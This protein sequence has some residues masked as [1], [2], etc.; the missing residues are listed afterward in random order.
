MILALDSE[1]VVALGERRGRASTEAH[2]ALA[3]AVRNR[4]PVVVPAVVLAELYRGPHRSSMVDSLLSRDR[5][6]HVLPTDRSLARLVGGVLLAAGAG[7]AMMADAHVVAAAVDG[8]GGV[9]LTGDPGDLGRLAA[10]YPHITVV[11]VAT[12]ASAQEGPAR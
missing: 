3:S 8:G 2:A 4:R 7:S 9:V 11:D 5:G 10:P 12:G 1:A 6:I